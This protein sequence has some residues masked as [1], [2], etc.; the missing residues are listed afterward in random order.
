MP[1]MRSTLSSCFNN[2]KRSRLWHGW[3]IDSETVSAIRRLT[4][5]NYSQVHCSLSPPPPPGARTRGFAVKDA[6]DLNHHVHD[7]QPT[8]EEWRRGERERGKKK[9]RRSR[10]RQMM[11]VDV[12]EAGGS[13]RD[14]DAQ[15]RF[16]SHLCRFS[17]TPHTSLKTWGVIDQWIHC[18]SVTTCPSRV[19][20]RR[21]W[22]DAPAGGSNTRSRGQ[23]W[24]KGGWEAQSKCWL[25]ILKSHSNKPG[26][27]IYCNIFLKRVRVY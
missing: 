21:K 27:D 10:H 18:V 24:L 11:S 3:L 5:T 7:V 6:G 16:W 13:R 4:D 9:S 1:E 2:R 17:C 25:T 19:R 22:R 15:R 23:I 8:S 20:S 14:E 26:Y 12:G